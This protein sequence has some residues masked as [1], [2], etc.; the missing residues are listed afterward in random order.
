MLRL[1]KDFADGEKKVPS[2]DSKKASSS[3]ASGGEAKEKAKETGPTPK[4]WE[5]SKAAPKP[6]LVRMTR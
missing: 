2:D 5:R 4:R 1:L 6:E 3:S